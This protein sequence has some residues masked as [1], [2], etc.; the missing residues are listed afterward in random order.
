MVNKHLPLLAG[1]LASGLCWRDGGA[2]H[3][4]GY[5]DECTGR[6]APEAD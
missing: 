6:N 5:L 1:G 4:G 2:R 3:L